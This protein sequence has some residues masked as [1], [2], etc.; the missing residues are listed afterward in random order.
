M[1]LVVIYLLI[2]T[3]YLV[4]ILIT[5]QWPSG[6]IGYLVSSVAAVGI[7]S[8]LLV[9]PIREQG[10]NRWVG[11]Y[12]RWFYVA[13]LP[14]IGML[15]VA[16]GKRIQQYGIT[17]DRYFL[18]V[19]AL[20]LAGIAIGYIARR[21]AGIRAIP[22]TLCLLAFVTAFGPQGA[23]GVS[24]R[25]QVARLRALLA[26]T[27]ASPSGAP[28]P[29]AADVSFETRL[30]LSSTLTYLI[31]T[32]GEQSLRGVLD[33]ELRAVAVPVVPS[34]G[35][36]AGV[37]Q[38]KPT[39]ANAQLEARAIMEHLG[40]VYV[41]KWQREPSRSFAYYDRRATQAEPVRV[42]GVD[43]HV[44]LYGGTPIT[45]GLE[46][47]SWALRQAERGHVLRLVRDGVTVL[48]FPV[49]TLVGF[50]QAHG[51]SY[52]TIPRPQLIASAGATRAMLSLRSYSGS[53]E[54]DSTSFG[55]FEGDLYL[56]VGRAP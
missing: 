22:V 24:R 49:D 30:A 5:G 28:H 8:L 42:T 2:L 54:S 31:G 55:Y 53:R 45:F 16:I 14:S 41:E 21:N 7:L 43:Y 46:G 19:L 47:A 20:W 33:D 18:G 36:P 25:S 44:R 29:V 11:T 13:L 1:P 9:H 12:A 37:V 38:A 32:H 56:T 48:D 26:K 35:V 3:T 6:W 52:D 51:A 10:E 17:E 23:Y 4:R 27:Q 40:L 39:A 15:L 50:A 34:H